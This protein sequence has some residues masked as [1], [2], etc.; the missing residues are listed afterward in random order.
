MRLQEEGRTC[1]ATSRKV[2]PYGVGSKD[3]HV[4]G[5]EMDLT[6]YTVYLSE[7]I[8][9]DKPSTTVRERE[10]HAFGALPT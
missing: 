1:C 9:E 3:V 5:G 2:L 6:Q 7:R 8:Q 4:S 10:K